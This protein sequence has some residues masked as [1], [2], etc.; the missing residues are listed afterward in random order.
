MFIFPS[1][2]M[3]LCNTSLSDCQAM[4]RCPLPIP[5]STFNNDG[6]I[7]AH[8]VCT[9]FSIFYNLRLCSFQ[10]SLSPWREAI[11]RSLINCNDKD[12]PS[13]MPNGTEILL[14]IFC[15]CAMIGARVLK[16]TTQQQR[17]PIF[18]CIYLRSIQ[19][20]YF[21]FASCI[22][23]LKSSPRKMSRDLIMQCNG[24][25]FHCRKPKWKESQGLEELLE[26]E[27]LS[28]EKIGWQFSFVFS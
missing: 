7:F 22:A 28:I 8:A 2:S 1:Q 20:N 25:L 14:S 26:G 18:I 21:E 27:V 15:R 9:V 17:R 19:V 4:S 3:Q 24:V 13:I 11:S 16:I 12:V 5:C 23:Q 6:S 10:W